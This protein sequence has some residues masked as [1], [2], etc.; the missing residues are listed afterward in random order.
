MSD[1]K[2][3]DRLFQEKLKDF[4]ATPSD[5][6]WEN[7]HNT[8]HNKKNKKR[9]VIPIWW[10][11]GGVAATL[12]LIL[13]I[14]G[15]FNSNTDSKSDSIKTVVDNTENTNNT[16][17]SNGSEKN[18]DNNNDIAPVYNPEEFGVENK[19]NDPT[20]NLNKASDE[21]KS[22]YASTINTKN[23]PI[24]SKENKNTS[25][26]KTTVKEAI[27]SAKEDSNKL[28]DQTQQ[29]N[30]N[31]IKNKLNELLKTDTK[32]SK[33]VSTGSENND[34]IQK[35]DSVNAITS[36]ALNEDKN[37]KE[38]AL[39]NAIA[40]ANDEQQNEKEEELK[41]RW[42]VSPNVAP[43]Y[44]NTL[45]N[46]SSIHNQ[47]NDNIKSGDVNM[48]YG[49]TG[50]YAINDKLKVRA[51]L[52]KVDL[53]YSTND[54]IFYNNPETVL[55]L[56]LNT[57]QSDNT[58]IQNINYRSESANVSFISASSLS[59]NNTPEIIKE[60]SLA[61][62][63]Q[64]FGFIEI[65]VELE[66]TVLDKRLGI[67]L[68][69]GFSTMFLSNNEIYVLSNSGDRTLIGE[70]NNINDMSYS[71]NFGIGLNYGLSD[72]FNINL[73]PMF[74]YQINTFNNTTGNFQPYFIGVYTGLSFKF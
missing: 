21:T 74:K 30:S 53:G 4:E 6:V 68:I 29:S 34:N 72:K 59:L 33:V 50:S 64:Q 48:S 3:I 42:S 27:A 38:N 49:I 66:Y 55:G 52:N 22:S 44:F 57:P 58:R 24:Y 11:L 36:I 62:L 37:L 2:N 16:V 69:G 35:T 8:L 60:N 26:T 18:N 40:K 46:G 23:T 13:T 63:D 47:F 14:S 10:Q 71:A 19:S 28:N 61:S 67:N 70:A 15:V 65:P 41:N 5:A 17:V 43:V 12:L 25:I 1:K 20:S 7:I 54:V 9:R 32:G 39:E 51:G 45:G 56:S 73:E 31:I